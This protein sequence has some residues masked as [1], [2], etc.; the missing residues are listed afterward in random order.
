VVFI[1]CCLNS[2]QLVLLGPS[3]NSPGEIVRVLCIS[4]YRNQHFCVGRN[5]CCY[6][7]VG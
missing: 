6:K 3:G 2:G 1:V 4:R 5:G 7:K